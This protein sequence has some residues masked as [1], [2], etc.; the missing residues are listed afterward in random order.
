M[1]VS[2]GDLVSSLVGGS[3]RNID[4]AFETA[5][6]NLQCL[7]Q[8]T[9]D[10]PRAVPTVGA[11]LDELAREAEGLSPADLKSLAQEAALAAMARTEEGETASVTH[12]DF[13]EA[14]SRLRP[15]AARSTV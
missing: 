10:L 1:G 15:R 3:S 6:Q 8:P 4:K 2:T 11:R 13:K 14:L 7:G 9:P 5:M 12:E